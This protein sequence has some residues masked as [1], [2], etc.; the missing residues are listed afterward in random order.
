M[1]KDKYQESRPKI[2]LEILY[3]PVRC[4]LLQL[5]IRAAKHVTILTVYLQTRPLWTRV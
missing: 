1:K 5:R 2:C 3:V 4:K